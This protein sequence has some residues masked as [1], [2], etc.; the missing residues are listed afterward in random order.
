VTFDALLGA[1]PGAELPTYAFQRS[2]YWLRPPR[3]TTDVAAA[4]LSPGE[5][6]RLGAAVRTAG[7]EAL[8]LTGRLS[9]ADQPW[10]AD[11]AVL[12]TVLLPARR[13]SSWHC[14]RRSSSSAT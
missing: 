2:T 1:G 13:S 11:H 10:L 7:S 4:G 9:V 14:T 12:G 6:P 3:T 8:L 5:H